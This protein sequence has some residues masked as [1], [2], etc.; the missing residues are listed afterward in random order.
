M[1]GV[2]AVAGGVEHQNMGLRV[3]RGEMMMTSSI[4]YVT[5]LDEENRAETMLLGIVCAPAGVLMM[6]VP[7]R[8]GE[9]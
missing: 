7:S 5:D 2:G 3:K 8:I 9:S 6:M 4:L 1:A